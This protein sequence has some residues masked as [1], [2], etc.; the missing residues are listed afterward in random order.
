MT[1]STRTSALASRHRELGS[2]LE[3]WN[4]NRLELQH[5]PLMAT[6]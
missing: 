1:E 3:D 6:I 5:R 2:D 4:G